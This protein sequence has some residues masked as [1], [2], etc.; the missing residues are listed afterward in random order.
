MID[1]PDGRIERQDI[2]HTS[3][4]QLEGPTCDFLTILEVISR[5]AV[6]PFYYT[7]ALDVLE[8]NE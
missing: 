4:M 2:F 8:A 6:D 1:M 3:D 5:T 7:A